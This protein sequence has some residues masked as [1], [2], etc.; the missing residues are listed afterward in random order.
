ME[1]KTLSTLSIKLTTLIIMFFLSFS[2]RS[3][4]DIMDHIINNFQDGTTLN[5]QILDVHIAWSTIPAYLT[6]TYSPENNEVDFFKKHD[7]MHDFVPYIDDYSSYC[8]MLGLRYRVMYYLDIGLDGFIG[9]G[10]GGRLYVKY[11]LSKDDAK[12]NY[13]LFSGISYTIEGFFYKSDKSVSQ[14]NDFADK[15]TMLTLELGLPMSYDLNEN[16]KLIFGGK[17]YWYSFFLDA[18]ANTKIIDQEPDFS[19]HQ[20]NYQQTYNTFAPAINFGI[21]GWNFCIESSLIY[22]EKNYN[23]AEKNDK[24]RKLQIYF[25]IGYNLTF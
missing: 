10:K 12:F 6:K 11:Q 7:K 20:M 8:V 21:Q 16:M 4:C 25:G 5:D 15:A 14:P 23:E 1:L 17:I 13:S 2:S 22:R 24:I 19:I 3:E 18:I 9:S